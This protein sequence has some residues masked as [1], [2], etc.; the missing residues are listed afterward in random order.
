M[1]EGICILI[2]DNQIEEAVEYLGTKNFKYKALFNSENR[3]DYYYKLGIDLL[4]DNNIFSESIYE[5]KKMTTKGGK[6]S[7]MRIHVNIMIQNIFN[8]GRQFNI[9]NDYRE[10]GN[11]VL[12]M[13]DR[14]DD[15]AAKTGGRVKL[16]LNQDQMDDLMTGFIDT[17]YSREGL[18]VRTLEDYKLGININPQKEHERFIA[19]QEELAEEEESKCAKDIFKH[20]TLNFKFRLITYYTKLR[21]STMYEIMEQLD[22]LGYL[23]ERF[24]N[25]LIDEEQARR[26]LAKRLCT[27]S[28]RQDIEVLRENG[29]LKPNEIQYNLD[30]NLD[31]E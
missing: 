2:S 10:C 24:D 4:N 9:L 28:F 19:R 30:I 31:E 20:F 5:I 1:K 12:I 14:Y 16:K 17:I 25:C 7:D 11:I 26:I 15:K 22:R 21:S 18:K 8:E 23:D 27:L 3:E 29:I 13:S 6:S